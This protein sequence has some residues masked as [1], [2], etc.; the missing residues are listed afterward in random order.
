MIRTCK[1]CNEDIFRKKD[2]LKHCGAR[3]NPTKR[4]LM[5]RGVEQ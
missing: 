4:H 5:N 3:C 1:Y 2:L